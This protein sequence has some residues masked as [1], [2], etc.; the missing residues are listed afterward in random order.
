MPIAA[1][2]KTLGIRGSF[3]GVFKNSELLH[4]YTKFSNEISDKSRNIIMPYFRNELKIENKKDSSPVTQADKKAELFLRN[5]IK[6]KFPQDGVYGEEYGYD[7]GSSDFTWVIDPIDG[8]KS[9]ISGMPLFGTLIALLH[10]D[11]PVLGII[12]IPA[13]DERWFAAQG[14]GTLFNGNPVKTRACSSLSDAGCLTTTPFNFTGHD[15]EKYE[16]VAG[17]VSWMRFGGDCYMYGLLA[18]GFAD[19]VFE[20]T[21]Q[22]YDYLA[23]APIIQE[24]GGSIT[25]WQ[26]KPLSLNSSGHVI[27]SGDKCVHEEALTILRT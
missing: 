9:F 13:L 25:D 8:T 2:I 12:D 17:T 6:Q 16:K 26:G 10:K 24:A 1:G 14:E 20:A 3:M 4:A 19:L 15:S 18:S 21:L 23:L 5:E 22:P 11:T 27:A 7:E